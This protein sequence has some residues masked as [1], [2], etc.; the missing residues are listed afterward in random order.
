MKQAMEF[1]SGP[2][3]LSVGARPRDPEADA[4]T[5]RAVEAALDRGEVEAAVALAE[6]ALADGQ[7]HPTLFSLAAENLESQDRYGEAL[8]LLERGHAMAPDDLD[9]R[10]ALGLCLFRLQRYRP[11][12]P[13]FDA[14]IAAEPEFSPAHAARGATLDAL[15]DLPAAEAAYGRA[16][17]FD[18]QNLLAVAGLASIA[19]RSGRHPEA[20]ALA[21]RVLQAQPG[22]PEAILLLAK[23]DLAQGLF[24]EADGRLRAM[25]ADPRTSPE[26]QTFAQALLADIPK[27]SGQTPD[28]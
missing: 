14:L 2:I 5:L 8:L 4:A 6:A 12:L 22:Y 25:I 9:L 23:A 27:R 11:A 15:G 3:K 17:E 19:S 10:Q 20:R 26:Q 18:P 28:A 13:H 7:A 16:L 1:K 24:A 21:E